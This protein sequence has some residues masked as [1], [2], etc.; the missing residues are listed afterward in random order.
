MTAPLYNNDAPGTLITAL[1]ELL[2]WKQPNAT[3]K[4]HGIVLALGGGGA[5]GLAHIGVLQVLAENAIPV[6]AIA[7]TSIGAEIGAFVASG[8]SLIEL[9]RIATE[10][11]W[12]ETLQLFMPD[13]PGGGLVSGKYIIAFLERH[14]GAYQIENL[15]LPFIAIATDLETGAQVIIDTGRLADAVRASISV[16]G[17][18]APHILNQRRLIDGGVVNPLP[19]DV[20]RERFGGPVVAITV[21]NASQHPHQQTQLT[22]QPER[23]QQLL[24]H[25]WMQRAPMLRNWLEAQINNH[26]KQPKSPWSLRRVIDR[27]TDIRQQHIVDLRAQ[28]SPPDLIITPN[29][30]HIGM[31]EF[32]EATSAIAA[33]REAALAH[34]PA[35]RELLEGQQAV[36]GDSQHTATRQPV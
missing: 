6:R 17:V 5:R 32:Y 4:V 30:S 22:Q 11:D 3:E 24:N 29:V 27:A 2:P 20:A 19:F 25:P 31:L 16:P 1:K 18:M 21:D 9:T 33:G 28:L 26:D 7:G 15:T 8:M 23:M 36:S 35:L 13:W 14:L 10:F 12:M 34:L